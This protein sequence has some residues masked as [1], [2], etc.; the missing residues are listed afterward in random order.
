MAV[1][2][3]VAIIRAVVSGGEADPY[4]QEQSTT[5]DT[6]SSD[7]T[8]ETAPD[9]T[10]VPDV[11]EETTIDPSTVAFI[12]VEPMELDVPYVDTIAGFEFYVFRTP[13]GTQYVEFRNPELVG[14]KCSDDLGSFASIIEDPATDEAATLTKTVDLD[15]TR[16][17][18][19]LASD[20][21]TSNAQLLDEYQSAFSEAFPLLKKIAS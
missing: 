17:G 18:L 21:C 5:Q 6:S 14:T 2:A 12:A 19:S 3:G 15:G 9:S 20:T 16:Y 11:S 8:D 4:I 13:A 10:D 1:I 7:A